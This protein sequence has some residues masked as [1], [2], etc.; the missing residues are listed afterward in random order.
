MLYF[1]VLLIK[2]SKLISFNYASQCICEDE[3]EDYS[4]LW[5]GRKQTLY[6]LLVGAI[7]KAPENG[8]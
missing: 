6:E 1:Y 5:M 2:S 7:W 3:E 8:L 4:I